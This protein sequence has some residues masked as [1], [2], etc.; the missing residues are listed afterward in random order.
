M[1]ITGNTIIAG[2]LTCNEQPIFTKG[3]NVIDYDTTTYNNCYLWTF[4][5]S[6]PA[7]IITIGN[8]NSG[9]QIYASSINITGNTT[10]NNV[11]TC[12]EQ[13]IFS[14]GINVIDYDSTNSQNCYLWA[15]GGLY[16]HIVLGNTDSDLYLASNEMHLAGLVMCNN[17]LNVLGKLVVTTT[18]KCNTLYT[19]SINIPDNGAYTIPIRCIGY[20]FY[21]NSS[22]M[23]YI[24]NNT[25][26]SV[27]LTPIPTGL[28][29]ISICLMIQSSTP[30]TS[31]IFQ[32]GLT[33]QPNQWL[34]GDFPL[35]NTYNNVTFD[36]FMC[37][38]NLGPFYINATLFTLL[39]PNLYLQIFA[40]TN[41]TTT[42]TLPSYSVQYTRIA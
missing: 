32:I 1:Y 24:I 36:N 30:I 18:I 3:I 21:L 31:N 29:A 28:W 15:S 6:A 5:G 12:A 9:I 13:P 42:G 25:Y 40:L 33:I 26:I 7:H 35:Y 2:V 17:D 4:A 38:Y 16:R 27:L 34:Y 19:G 20:T 41:G 14:K 22:F 8:I 11:L 39:N 23:Y 10:I 37:S